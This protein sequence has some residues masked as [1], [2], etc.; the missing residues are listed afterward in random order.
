M[1]GAT[2]AMAAPDAL[3]AGAV[4]DLFDRS[5]LSAEMRKAL[6]DRYGAHATLDLIAIV[7]FY[8]VLGC[9]LKSFDTPVD[10]EIGAALEANPID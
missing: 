8:K 4:D 5:Q 10:A 3:I 9:I 1:R 6:L 2:S 7:G